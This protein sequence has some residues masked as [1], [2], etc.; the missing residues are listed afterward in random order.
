M[1]NWSNVHKEFLNIF[2][3]FAYF[4][5]VKFNYKRRTVAEEKYQN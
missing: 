5:R 4:H 3:I 1:Y 2:I